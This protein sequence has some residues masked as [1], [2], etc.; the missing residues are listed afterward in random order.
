MNLQDKSELC[1]SYTQYMTLP[2]LLIKPQDV[3]IIGVGGGSNIRFLHHHFPDAKIVG[4]DTSAEVL[5]IA[6][7]YFGLPSHPHVNM[8]CIPGEEFLTQTEQAFNL[9]QLDAFDKKGM[10]ASIYNSNFFFLCTKL[11]TDDGLLCCNIWGNDQEHLDLT[12]EMLE[13]VFPFTIYIP[14]PRR[15]NIIAISSRKPIDWSRFQPRQSSLPGLT[16][17]PNLDFRTMVK[18]ARRANLP[19]WKRLLYSLQ[20]A[21]LSLFQAKSPS[22][23]ES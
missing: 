17:Q 7:T 10:V 21:Y 6:H 11:L 13:N 9:I 19:R 4:V 15:G 1:L 20:D 18:V 12:K 5:K 22:P 2:L 3:L 8:H 16:S 14:V 23:Y